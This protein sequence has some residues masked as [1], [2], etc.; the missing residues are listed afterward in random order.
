MSEN[1]CARMTGNV[2]L[3]LASASS[4]RRELLGYFDV[5]FSSVTTTAED[6]DDE[7]PAEVVD[8]LPSLPLLLQDHPVLL[9]WRKANAVLMHSSADVIIGADT[10]V[11]IDGDVLN[12]PDDQ[13]QAQA[14]LRR[15]SGRTHTVYTG[16]TAMRPNTAPLFDI[17]TSQV[18]MRELTDAMIDWYVSSGEPMDKAGAYGIQGLGGRLVRSVAGSYTNV[19]G[20]PL[21][22]TYHL[23]VA[24]G[25]LLPVD[26]SEAYRRWLSAQGKEPLPCPPTFP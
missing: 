13:L 18:E 11:V 23:L 8:A 7:P 22:H 24:A 10:I 26:P 5:P 16:L 3:I 14:M 19:V 2:R 25:I 1:S 15:L 6:D 20:L 17:A 12:K 4:R 9:A 21:T